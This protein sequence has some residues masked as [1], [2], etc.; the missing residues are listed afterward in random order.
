MRTHPRDSISDQN[1]M[2]NDDCGV[3]SESAGILAFPN[4]IKNA[5]VFFFFLPKQ[6]HDD[7]HTHTVLNKLFIIY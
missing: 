3:V 1:E 6:D 7:D 4:A 5:S 2:V